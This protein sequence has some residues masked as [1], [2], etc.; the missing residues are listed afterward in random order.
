MASAPGFAVASTP[1]DGA[2]VHA[3]ISVKGAKVWDL[4]AP[5]LY[6]LRIT[7]TLPGGQ[8][9]IRIVT[10]GF[11]W[12]A[13]SGLG[14][15]AIFRLNGR[16]IKIYTA[17]SWGFWGHNGL[18]P[19]KEL[20]EREVTQAKRLNLNCLNFHRNVGKEEVLRAHDRLGLLRYMEPGGGKLA[21]GKLPTGIAANAPTV[22]MQSASNSA[23][24]FSRKFMLAKCR[25]MVRAFRSHPSLI[26]YTLQNELGADL[27][28]PESLEAI[29][30]MHAEDPSRSVVL[31]DGFVAPPRNAAQPGTNRTKPRY[32]EAIVRLGEGGGSITRVLVTN[33]TTVSMKTPRTL[34][35]ENR[36]V[37]PWSS[38]A[39][40]KDAP[41]PTTTR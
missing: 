6:L 28:N 40:W 33:G 8:K 36:C 2:H 4:N 12:F 10:F 5:A 29:N 14:K 27:N 19:T 13:P 34:H 39:R 22:V 26:Q 37:K 7:S 32:T 3:T 31:N 20:A 11:R 30:L 23:D 35:I 25:Y 1:A 18:F 9:D 15:D 38:L 24:Q 16:R 41:S 21:I 17:I